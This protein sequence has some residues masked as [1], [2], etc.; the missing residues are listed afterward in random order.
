MRKILTM[1][2]AL[3]AL[4]GQA[5]EKTI[6]WEQP[7]IEYSNCCGDG[8]FSLNLDV[9]KV[10]LKAAET[11]VYITMKRS[12]YPEYWFRFVSDTYLKVGDKRYTVVSAD[13]IEL[14]KQEYGG[15]RDIVFHFPSL[16]KGTKMFDFIEGDGEGAFQVKGIKPVE[17]RWKQLFPSYWRD[18]Q[19]GDWKIAFFEDFAIYDCKFWGYKQCDVNPKTGEAEI[20]IGK[21]DEELKVVVGKDKK[22]TRIL[23]I[24]NQ[25]VACSMITSRFLPDYPTKDTR[26]TFKDTHYKTDTVTFIG[27]LKDMPQ[28]QKDMGDEFKVLYRDIFS[29]EQM[30]SFGKMNSKGYFLVKIPLLNSSEVLFDWKHTFIRTLFE[31]GE[32]YFLLYDFKEGRRFYMG[33]D[34][35]LQ[36][37][38]LKYPMKWI[39][40]N[41]EDDMDEAIAMQF[42]EGLKQQKKELMA[43]LDQVVKAHPNISDRY[44]NFLTGSYNTSEGRELMQ[45]RFYI[46]DRNI[47]AEYLNYVNQQHWQ[48]RSQPYTLYGDFGTFRRDYID[49][50]ELDRYAVKVGPGFMISY[51][52]M[53]EPVLRRYRDAGKVSITDEELVAIRRYLEREKGFHVNEGEDA[54]EAYLEWNAKKEQQDNLKQYLEIIQREDI[55]KILD[56]E[57]ELLPLYHTLAILDSLDCDKDLHDIII[58]HALYAHLYNNRKPLKDFTMQYVEEN[59]SMEA[60]KAFIRA[61]QEKYLAIQRRDISNSPSLKSAEDVANMSDGEKMLRKMIEP[62]KGKIILLDVWGTWCAPCKMALSHSAEEYERLKDYDLVYLYLA[63]NSEEESWKNVIK[64]YNVLGDNVVHYNLPEDQQSAIEHFLNVNYYP[65]YK[66]IDKEGNILNVN[67]SPDDLEGLARLLEQMK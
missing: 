36:N 11:L 40:G 59:V 45:G 65:T 55:K 60:A 22:G 38:M 44:V 16:P 1:L 33:N 6:V 56:D 61:E 8:T 14:D 31:P 2:F 41:P 29:N 30:S 10:E 3:V 42:L 57:Q 50:L 37:E 32:T 51:A 15:K 21:G 49:Q 24:G 19:T 52:D 64:E 35:R 4:A 34:C 39:N 46:K 25:T 63:N 13:G 43:S 12:L 23:Q 47:P 9:T 18:D 53:Y 48:K 54:G 7:T 5:K 67:A 26:T 28:Q 58:A 17:E 27:W 66:L 62:Y 20:L